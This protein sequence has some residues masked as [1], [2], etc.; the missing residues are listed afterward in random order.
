MKHGRSFCSANLVETAAALLRP[1]RSRAKTVFARIVSR[2]STV[3][4][5]LLTV[6]PPRF[7]PNFRSM[8]SDVTWLRRSWVRLRAA[9]P[10]ELPEP[11]DLQCECGTRV[12]GTRGR[13]WK[14][15]VCPECMAP[16]FVLPT[17]VYPTTRR[18]PSD[19]IPGS[20]LRRAAVITGDLLRKQ[21]QA[22]PQQPDGSAA[23][24]PSDDSS[25]HSTASAAERR[26]P[27]IRPTVLLRR[28]FTPFRLI[29]AGTL[30]AVVLTG[31]TVVH[32]RRLDAART[33]WLRAVDQV[34]QLLTEGDLPALERTLSSACRAA[35]IIGRSD[36][37]S[38]LMK[39]LLEQTRAAADLNRVSLPA[40][41]ASIASG[42]PPADSPVTAP[43]LTQYAFLVDSYID[44]S[45]TGSP[46]FLIDLPLLPDQPARLTVTLPPLAEY[47]ET[48]DDGRCLFAFRVLCAIPPSLS[49][50]RGWQVVIDPQSFVLFTSP[51]LC[52]LLGLL[53]NDASDDAL[54]ALLADQQRF[55]ESSVDWSS[56]KDRL[57][58]PAVPVPDSPETDQSEGNSE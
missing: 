50:G 4:N 57:P 12:R 29:V 13:T 32:Q 45:R 18:V 42:R 28:T 39:S 15:T 54:L 9:A 30:L 26:L 55:V 48:R 2:T 22:S 37:Q 53:N 40:V 1:R 43:E 31:A 3:Y 47:L 5:D 58:R 7:R 8:S 25:E 33:T 35:Q 17:N 44:S 27:R 6:G 10:D 51:D 34:P 46:E 23:D 56:R 19:V 36:R 41:I 16:L 24:S 21:Q 38:R 14:Q 49:D 11:Y 52:R 20:L